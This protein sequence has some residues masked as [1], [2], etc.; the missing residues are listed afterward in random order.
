MET[1]RSWDHS[2]KL[3]G[4]VKEADICPKIRK[5]SMRLT[6]SIIKDPF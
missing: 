5:R 1:L 3:Q 2:T 6:V 4:P